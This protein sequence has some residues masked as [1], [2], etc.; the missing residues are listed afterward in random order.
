[1]FSS[2][3]CLSTHWIGTFDTLNNPIPKRFA[4]YISSNLPD[5]ESCRIYFDY[6]TET[7][8]AL[9]EPYQKKIDALMISHGYDDTNWKTLK[10]E[11]KDHSEKSWSERLT[12]PLE[13]ILQKI[14]SLTTLFL[15]LRSMRR[16]SVLLLKLYRKSIFSDWPFI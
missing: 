16:E 13:F 11:G 4:K 7:L 12:I 10:F 6:G 5:P 15:P 9:Y 2:A 8:D 1:V 14:I 3:A